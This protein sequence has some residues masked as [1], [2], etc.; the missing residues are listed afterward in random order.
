[1]QHLFRVAGGLESMIVGERQILGQ[2]RA[3]FSTA[4]QTGSVQ[5]PLTR[6][7]HSAL[8][9]GRRVHRETNIGRHS[10]SVSRAAV[11]LARGMFDRLDDRRAL[12]I[13]AGDAGR[14]VAWALG[15]AGVKAITVTNR[16]QWRAE[17]LAKEL[18][19]VAAPFEGLQSALADADL[20]ISSTGSPGYVV[21]TGMVSEAVRNR[22]TSDPL[23]LIDIAV[24]RDVDPAVAELEGVRLYDIDAL[25]QVAETA[26]DSL[27]AEVSAATGIIDEEWTRFVERWNSSETLELVAAMRQRAEQVRRL[28]VERTL[29]QLGADADGATA[30][31]LHAMT[32][33]LV[34]KLL[35][36][37]TVGLRT[38]DSASVFPVAQ[39]LFD[40]D[41]KP[42]RGRGR[43]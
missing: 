8:R 15:D 13:G 28:E 16:T 19:G 31:R 4:S 29:K 30:E 9:A 12:V 6:V 21:D 22:D 10:R 27:D 39:Q 33:A 38:G 11:Q 7:F 14:M 24:P 34:K 3:S 43:R 36:Q 2:V 42:D 17:D 25:G 23:M 32:A 37:P 20:V 18:G 1:M 40:T 5:S 35:H 26:L 41:A